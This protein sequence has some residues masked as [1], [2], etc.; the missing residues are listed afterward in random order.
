MSF[1]SGVFFA[2]KYIK[3]QALVLKERV[4]CPKCGG[5]AIA[6]SHPDWLRG[7]APRWYLNKVRRAKRGA[8]RSRVRDG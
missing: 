2:D 4:A 6:A 3:G 5:D 1:K 8:R 7:G